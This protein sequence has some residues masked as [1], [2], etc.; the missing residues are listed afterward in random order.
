MAHALP[1]GT[2]R[3]NEEAAQ[4]AAAVKRITVVQV[5]GADTY[6]LAAQNL[7]LDQRAAVLRQVGLSFDA[8]I[9][10]GDSILSYAV[11]VWL[12]RRS[13]GE[14]GL[15]WAQFQRQWP[16]DLDEGELDIWAENSAGQRIDEFGDVVAE[17]EPETYE[18]ETGEPIAEDED[19]EA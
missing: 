1:P 10:S 16:D 18:P 4:A 9:A 5:R 6:R 14:R 13:H 19:P 8:I 12:A 11:I 15:S 7:P 2:A 17:P 3:R